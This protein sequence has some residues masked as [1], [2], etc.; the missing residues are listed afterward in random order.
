MAI[1]ISKSGRNAKKVEKS[2]FEKEDYVQKY[3]HD[4][5]ESIPLYEFKEDLRLFVLG[6]EFRTSSGP[7]DVIG[8]DEDGDIY[9]IE[10]KLYKNPD[11][12]Q[13]VAQVL[14]YGASLWRSHQDFSEFIRWAEEAGKASGFSLDQRLKA[15][16]AV[17]EDGVSDLDV[18]DMLEIVKTNLNSGKFKF[19][20]LMDKLHESLKNLIIFP[21]QNSRFDIFAVELE[22]YK[23]E[24]FEIMIPKLFGAEVK[25]DVQVVDSSR[26][27][28]EEGFFEDA[29]NRKLGETD[30][31]AIRKLF[32][33]SQIAADELSWGRGAT[34]ASFSPKFHK[35]SHK[36]LYTVRSTG[37]MSVNLKWLDD[38]ENSQRYRDEFAKMLKQIPALSA[39]SNYQS[40]V[41]QIPAEKWCP[42]VDQ[43][44]AAVQKLLAM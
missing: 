4:N 42:V 29:E 32:D 38:L 13:V 27:W 30:I 5:P 15:F 28:G 20:I 25:K 14:D 17:Q 41:P 34:R 12:R 1:I 44:I 40:Q 19:V 3:I 11:K 24:E 23:H 36:S 35:V 2:D 18:K 6:R 22:F 26:R 9:C 16:L 33:F 37:K 31:A 21:N 8:I 10:T 7:I 43:F 39:A